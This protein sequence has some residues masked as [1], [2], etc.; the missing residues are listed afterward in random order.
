ME[1]KEVAQ[2]QRRIDFM[3]ISLIKDIVFLTITECKPKSILFN[4]KSLA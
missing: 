2:K 1:K 4:K 3:K